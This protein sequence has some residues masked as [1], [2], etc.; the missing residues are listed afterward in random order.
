VQQPKQR[1]LSPFLLFVKQRRQDFEQHKSNG[2]QMNMKDFL[3]AAGQEWH[4]L[5]EAE[6]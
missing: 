6:K 3:Y 5:T 4:K 2:Q 1:K